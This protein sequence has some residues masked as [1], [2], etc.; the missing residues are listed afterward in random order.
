MGKP[1]KEE[2]KKKIFEAIMIENFPKLMLDAKPQI[3]EV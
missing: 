2:R 1:E 3:Q